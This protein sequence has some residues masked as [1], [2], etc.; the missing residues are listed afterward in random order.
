MEEEDEVGL[1]KGELDDIL[2]PLNNPEASVSGKTPLSTNDDMSEEPERSVERLDSDGIPGKSHLP[3]AVKMFN[4]G[5]AQRKK[6]TR[7]QKARE[8]SEKGKTSRKRKAG[9]DFKGELSSEDTKRTN[10]DK[11]VKI[12]D[13]IPG[14]GTVVVG[15]KIKKDFDGRIYS[16][17]IVGYELLYKVKYE[18]GDF[19]ELTWEELQPRLVST[20]GGFLSK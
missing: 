16:G 14:R 6:P 9:S 3:M 2:L 17:E 11:G 1:L 8:T 12:A 20:Q 10:V 13:C 18:D 5:S 7:R 4:Y 19:E 15:S